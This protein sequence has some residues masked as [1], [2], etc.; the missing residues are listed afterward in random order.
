MSDIAHP[1]A[2]RSHSR[3]AAALDFINALCA[4]VP[5]ALIAL[6]IRIIMAR[7][8][9]MSGQDKIAGPSVPLDLKD[10]NF[11]VTLPAEVKAATVEMFRTKFA[12][13]PLPPDFSAYFVSYAEFFLPILLL[14]GFATRLS[15]AILLVMTVVI[16][17]FVLPEA[18][19][20]V[21]AY[22][23]A[24]LLVLMT[25]GPGAVSVDHVIRFLAGR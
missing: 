25:V 20:T 15:A 4:V 22:W 11:S 8:F 7:V 13:V 17:V 9:F 16:Q 10:F 1:A 2:P 3:I 12:A 21:H 5:Y 6:M 18:L 14:L 24:L 19:W 23:A